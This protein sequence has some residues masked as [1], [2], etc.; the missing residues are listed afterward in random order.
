MPAFVRVESPEKVR[1]VAEHI[2]QREA[3]K[4]SEWRAQLEQSIL[5]LADVY[6]E[7]KGPFSS[8]T[9]R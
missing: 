6:T 4:P 7:E 3:Q 2:S 1:R 8:T 5:S 9:P